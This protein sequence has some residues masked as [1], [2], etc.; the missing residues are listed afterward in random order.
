MSMWTLTSWSMYSKFA[1]LARKG[2]TFAR[3]PVLRLSMQTTRQPS[4]RSLSQRWLPM[5]PDPPVTSALGL[6]VAGLAPVIASSETP[7]QQSCF[8]GGRSIEGVTAVHDE[9][10]VPHQR[11]GLLGIQAPHLLPLGYYH[12]RVGS[13]ERLVGVE[14]GS[15]VGRKLGCSLACHRIIAYDPGPESG[16]GAGNGQ[17]GGL[18]EVVCVRL[19]REPEQG[20]TSALEGVEVPLK[21]VD[22]HSA[23]P[24][25]YG[26][27]RVEE[28]GL[29]FVLARCGPQGGH[30]FGEARPAPTE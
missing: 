6:L 18:S 30:V 7:V 22:N 21:L 12:R 16:Q 2:V 13:S 3:T 19:E 5:K 29:V 11:G 4:E 27:G 28:R 10:R 17:A 20:H 25:V 1:S 15:N 26:G 8:P 14:D 9:L 24:F 23:L